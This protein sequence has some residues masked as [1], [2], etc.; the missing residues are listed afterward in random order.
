MTA[1]DNE[2]RLEKWRC[3]FL[4]SMLQLFDSPGGLFVGYEA[5]HSKVCTGWC[6]PAA[7]RG[8]NGH[9]EVCNHASWCRERAHN[10]R[11]Q[12]DR[13]NGASR[14]FIHALRV[15]RERS[16]PGSMRNCTSIVLSNAKR[17]R[18]PIPLGGGGGRSTPRS[19]H[20]NPRTRALCWPV[21]KPMQRVAATVLATRHQT[22]IATC[23]TTTAA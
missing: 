5:K 7:D 1:G 12:K 23:F 17:C 11:C 18:S 8:V 9:T 3:A 16:L 15:D 4:T 22:V 14:S 6:A 21:L 10:T 2:K 20:T 13:T 19:Y